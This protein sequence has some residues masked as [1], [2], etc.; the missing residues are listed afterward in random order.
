MQEKESNCKKMKMFLPLRVANF[1]AS[2]LEKQAKKKGSRPLMTTFS[3]Y[4][5]ARNNTFN[6][7]KAKTELGYTARS[8]EETV[9]DQVAWLRKECKLNII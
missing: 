2:I 5:L 8:Y 7:T 3:V 9:K 1:L 6:Y 4:N